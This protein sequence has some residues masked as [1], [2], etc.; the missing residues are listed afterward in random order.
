MNTV[1]QNPPQGSDL[2]QSTEWIEYNEEDQT[3][4]LAYDPAIDDTS[5]AVVTAVA[6]VSGTDPVEV[7]PL[8]A[9]VDPTALDRLFKPTARRKSSRNGQVIFRFG[10]YTITVDGTGVIEVKDK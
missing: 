9:A 4:R 7:D 3:Y 8:H 5:L 10:E 1:E 2:T 6:T